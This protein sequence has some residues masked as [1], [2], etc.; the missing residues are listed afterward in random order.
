MSLATIRAGFGAALRTIPGLNVD[1]YIV[2]GVRPPHA[3]VD[4]EIEYDLTFARGAHQYTFVVMLFTQRSNPEQS[5]L[6]LD[7]LRDPENTGG[8]KQIL[9]GDTTLAGLVDYVRVTRVD[10]PQIAT[11]GNADY[12]L[13]TFEVEVVL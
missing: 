2:E 12:L 3:M 6:S 7:E 10:R 9:E 5:Q 11:V 1:E 13:V 4:C 8:I